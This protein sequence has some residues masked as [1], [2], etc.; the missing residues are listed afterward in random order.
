MFVYASICLTVKVRAT[1]SLEVGNER[2]LTCS[3][4]SANVGSVSLSA[5]NP[6]KLRA[7]ETRAA[8]V[9]LCTLTESAHGRE[10][11]DLIELG[12]ACV[13]GGSPHPRAARQ[14]RAHTVQL[15]GQRLRSRLIQAEEKRT[16]KSLNVLRPKYRSG[17]HYAGRLAC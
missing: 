13:E 16:F 5:M 6:R 11:P 17:L 14:F 15:D 4:S 3:T 12:K 9:E 7:Y 2:A 8:E 1:Y 10:L